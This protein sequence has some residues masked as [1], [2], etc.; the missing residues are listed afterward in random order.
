M[1]YQ[2]IM[3]NSPI[4]S[5]GQIVYDPKVRRYITSGELTLKENEIDDL[6][7]S[8]NRENPMYN[9][10]KAMKTHVEV[11]QDG[12][13]I[14]RGR[15]LKPT[16]EMN[17]SGNYVQTFVFESIFAYLIDSV[18]RFLEVHDTTPKDFFK[19]LI[20]VHNS[21]VPDYKKFVVQN[22][23]VTNN[24]DNVYRFVDYVS[25]WDTLKD[26]LLT[27]LGGYFTIERRNG[28][29]YI[30]YTQEAGVNHDDANPIIISQNMKSASVELDPTEVITRLIPLGSTIEPN[31][32]EN[33]NVETAVSYPRIDIT[34]VNYGKDYI[35]IPVLQDEFGVINGTKIWEDVT[36]PENLYSKARLWIANQIAAKENWNIS[37]LELP[38]FEYF[39]VSDRY[40]FINKEIATKQLLRVV[41][42]KID[43]LQPNSSQLTIGTKNLK[44]SDYKK[45]NKVLSHKALNLGGQIKVA[46]SKLKKT[47]AK[48]KEMSNTI[49]EQKKTIASLK[50]DVD[51]ADLRNI[52]DKLEELNKATNALENKVDNLDYVNNSD[53]QS[54]INIQK[55]I[56]EDYENRLKVLEG[57]SNS[58][59]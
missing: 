23:D 29:N 19:E 32:D 18:Q 16:K 33:S 59:N 47:S 50:Q 48:A 20:E 45:E 26:K 1:A 9:H 55:I 36:Q 40:P 14:F 35:D 39:N 15:A 42:K 43:F 10:V 58:D 8:V 46:N 53:F 51:N 38:K 5:L 31:D 4:S 17:D 24:T 34:D 57:G 28:G 13:L 54:E 6:V 27:R 44:L 11:I 21:Q 30:N 7:L 2:I 25:T 56:N 22:V 37:A 49:D 52:G 3:Y 41:Q 12:K